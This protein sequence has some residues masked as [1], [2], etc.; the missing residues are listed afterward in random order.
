MYG[1]MLLWTHCVGE[2]IYPLAWET[3]EA[4]D[5]YDISVESLTSDG[6]KPNRRF[7]RVCQKPGS[8]GVPYKCPNPFREDKDMF[9]ICD[10][11]HL[12]KT[13]R[14]C[15]SNSFSH[16][17][18]RMMQVCLCVCVRVRGCVRAC[19]C[20]MHGSVF[21]SITSFSAEKRPRDLME[22]D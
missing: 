21:M 3:I 22:V 20:S 1:I 10:A 11:P 4:L 5:M 15:F 16:S 13:T 7:Y 17:K 6:A 14:N 2:Q 18:S 19:V 8:K 9:F 12:L